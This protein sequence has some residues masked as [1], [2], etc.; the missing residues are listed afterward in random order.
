MKSMKKVFIKKFDKDLFKLLDK[1][2]FPCPKL[3]RI[4]QK[5]SNK[6][7]KEFLSLTGYF[8][9]ELYFWRHLDPNASY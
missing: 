4:P 6:Q 1:I 2:G 9:W 5:F 7:L 8:K 3:N